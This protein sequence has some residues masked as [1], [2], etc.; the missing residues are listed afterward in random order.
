M[1]AKNTFLLV[2]ALCLCAAMTTTYA[3]KGNGNGG[4]KGGDGG[5]GG[6]G[7]TPTG[8]IYYLGPTPGYAYGSVTFSMEPDGSNQAPVA[9]G[10]WMRAYGKPSRDLHNNHRWF[11]CFDMISGE[12]YPDGNPRGEL[13]AFRD[14]YDPDIPETKVQL[15][16]DITLAASQP[17]WLPGDGTISFVGKRWDGS[18]VVKGGIYTVDLVFDV[19]GNITGLAGTATTPTFTMPLYQSAPDVGLYSWDP[20][21]TMIVYNKLSEY[22]LWIDDPSGPEVKV[23]YYIAGGPEWSPDGGSILFSQSGSIWTMK[24]NGKR[25]VTVV[26][27]TS[28]WS[29]SQA[30]WSPDSQ[31]LVFRGASQLENKT[32][33]FRA[34]ANGSDLTQL[35]NNS[36]PDKSYTLH[37]FSAWR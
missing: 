14:D 30:H 15:T 19:D 7:S 5:P 36:E 31:Y 2:T 9:G 27:D 8:T 16:D 11:L 25:V 18:T 20:T 10:G 37:N 3:G 24:A 21:G 33:V 13:F 22:G 23:F 28:E 17:R 4:G 35:T 34:K 1:K 32:D 29:F 12:Y 26:P 6:G